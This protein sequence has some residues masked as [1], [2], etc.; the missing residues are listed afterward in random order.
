MIYSNL[1]SFCLFLNW[2]GAD[3]RPQTKPRKIYE[4]NGC[5]IV[6]NNKLHTL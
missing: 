1:G 2:E 4:Y 6:N 5:N 3:I